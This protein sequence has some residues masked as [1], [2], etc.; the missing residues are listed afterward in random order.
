MTT[1]FVTS[2][3]FIV[4][5]KFQKVSPLP[6]SVNKNNN[7][8]TSKLNE[9][10]LNHISI[11]VM[12]ITFLSVIFLPDFLARTGII[13][14]VNQNNFS[15]FLHAHGISVIPSVILPC[16][17]FFKK[18]KYLKYVWRELKGN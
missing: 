3:T 13:S 10:M 8:N 4:R 17:F 6:T 9:N 7:Y 1:I 2:L 14:Q 11:F 15:T 18:P 5:K 16:C 12:G